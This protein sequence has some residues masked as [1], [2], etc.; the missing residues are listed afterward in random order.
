M[1]F[2]VINSVK[3]IST[4]YSRILKSFE[5]QKLLNDLKYV[6]EEK[7]KRFLVGITLFDVRCLNVSREFSKR[8]Y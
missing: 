2:P 1:I 8:F 4:F 3:Y 6:K 7:I 5:D